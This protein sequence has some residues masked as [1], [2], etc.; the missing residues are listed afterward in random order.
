MDDVPEIATAL[1]TADATA[2][3]EALYREKLGKA[4]EP[5]FKKLAGHADRSRTP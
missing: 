4:T 2:A 1:V 5:F 3:F